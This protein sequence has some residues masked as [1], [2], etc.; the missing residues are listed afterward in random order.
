MRKVRDRG[1]LSSSEDL[2]YSPNVFERVASGKNSRL[3]HRI[4]F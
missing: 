4:E 3:G 1:T 2:D